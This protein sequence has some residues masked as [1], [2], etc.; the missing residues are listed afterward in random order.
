[1]KKQIFTL[2][3]ASALFFATS[4]NKEDDSIAVPTKTK[5]QLL[6]QSTWKFSNAT[7]GGTD[8]SAA[9]Q[10]CQKDNILTFIAAGIGSVDEGPL[11]C[12]A[13]D[14]QT[15][16]FLW[17]FSSGE[18][19]LNI[20]TVLFTG[21]SNTFTIVSLTETQLVA[22]QTITVGGTPQNAVVTFIH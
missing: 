19:V 12:N 6:F 18:T 5:T 13:G 17:S 4:C 22:S 7:V 16:S 10:P 11:K 15:N 8:V 20:S 1:M 9:I 3:A 14:P 2:L 21:G